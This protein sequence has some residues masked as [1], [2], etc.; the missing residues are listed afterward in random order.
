MLSTLLSM[1]IALPTWGCGRSPSTVRLTGI[2]PL[3]W[4]A[5]AMGRLAGGRTQI[6]PHRVEL[7]DGDQLGGTGVADQVADLDLQLADPPVDRGDTSGNS[8]D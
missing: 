4:S 2:P 7:L 6:E 3:A 1:K 8:P 5:V